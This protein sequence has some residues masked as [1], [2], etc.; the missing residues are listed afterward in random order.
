MRTALFIQYTI[1]DDLRLR[2]A[3]GEHPR[4][5]IIDLADQLS[6]EVVDH[7]TAETSASIIVR[8]LCNI[9]MPFALGLLAWN[10][11]H[12]F[13]VVYV[14]N[15]RLGILIAALLK[16]ARTRPRLVIVNHYLSNRKKAALFRAL[17]LK[18]SVDT[19]VCLNEYQALFLEQ[20]VAVRREK[21]ARVCYGGVVDGSFF[22]PRHNKVAEPEKAYILSVGRE[23]RDYS[24]FFD[25]V[26]NT[27]VHSKVVFGGLMPKNGQRYPFA[28]VQ[29]N[30][31]EILSLVSYPALR[32]LY[33]ECTFVVV[34]LLHDV[35]Y[36]AGI[37]A[38][39]EAM[40]MGKPVIATYSRGIQEFMQDS[41]T[42]FWVDPKNPAEL[43]KKILLLWNDPA[44]AR[45]MG[46]HARDW[47][48]RR[49]DMD[50]YVGELVSFI[51]T[52]P[53]RSEGR[54]A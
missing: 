54:F 11:K 44:L 6:A 33:A 24:T 12:E 20:E 34:P 47:V 36:P 28:G 25:A 18:N 26:R 9:Y 30:N 32:R 15:E 45:K 49:V 23:N 3:I 16:F 48:E 17:R 13:D 38:I 5:E 52:E 14:G 21:V 1:A 27:S 46:M 40:A 10:R 22:S 53:R 29:P 35:E 2:I 41:L 19:F 7:R 8:I 43:Q 4:S 50:R 42:G 31:V 37:T 51:R 39:L